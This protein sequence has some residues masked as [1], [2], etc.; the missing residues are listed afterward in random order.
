MIFSIF[1]QS[2]VFGFS[3]YSCVNYKQNKNC[4]D[5]LLITFKI[6]SYVR[7]IYIFVCDYISN[8]E[9]IDYII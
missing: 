5:L 4:I 8:F 6:E 3:N 7:L 2:Y 9:Q 1:L